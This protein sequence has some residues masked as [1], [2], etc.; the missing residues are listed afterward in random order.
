M[1]LTIA[2]SIQC[3][4]LP[5]IVTSTKPHLNFLVDT[6][7]S[8]NVIFSFVYEGLLDFFTKLGTEGTTFGIEG[9]MIKTQEVKAV[10]TFG[11]KSYETVFSVIEADEAVNH[12]EESNGFQLHGILGVDFLTKNKWIID[13]DKLKITLPSE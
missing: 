8:H 13:F 5:I 2:N 7:A 11:E 3:V 1:D 9:N 12:L 10:I 6:G 4:G